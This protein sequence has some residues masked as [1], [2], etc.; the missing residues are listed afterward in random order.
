MRIFTTEHIERARSGREDIY[1]VEDLNRAYQCRAR[2]LAAVT[3]G[4]P[5]YERVRDTYRAHNSGDHSR[6]ERRGDVCV[7]PLDERPM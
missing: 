6:C 7:D 5:E 4:W 2:R 1:T 3:R